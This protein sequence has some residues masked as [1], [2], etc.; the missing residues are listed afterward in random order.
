[1]PRLCVTLSLSLSLSLQAQADQ[2]AEHMRKM[3]EEKRRLRLLAQQKQVEES[4]RAPKKWAEPREKEGPRQKWVE[5]QQP[6]QL[7]RQADV[8]TTLEEGEGK[9]FATHV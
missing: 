8:T 5:F 4:E 2:Q 6:P 1:M 7:A 3:V 9:R